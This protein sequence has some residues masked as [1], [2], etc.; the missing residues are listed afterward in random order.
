MVAQSKLILGGGQRGD[1]VA[2]ICRGGVVLHD[3]VVDD[4]VVN[5]VFGHFD[6]RVFDLQLAL[7]VFVHVLEHVAV[8]FGEALGAADLLTDQ[9]DATGGRADLV[10]AF[11]VVRRV[12]KVT[13]VDQIVHAPVP[14]SHI[15]TSR[16]GVIAR[17]G[18]LSHVRPHAGHQ[19]FAAGIGRLVGLVEE[20]IPMFRR[21]ESLV[22]QAL[23][24]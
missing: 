3:H 11:V 9:V 8:D 21:L 17:Q 15:I 16:D 7:E 14:D 5:G 12:D 19:D 23:S 22:V 18:S 13:L 10:L 2:V 24:Q 6:G 4:L 20:F 1:A